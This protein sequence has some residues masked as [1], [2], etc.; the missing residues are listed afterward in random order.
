[1]SFFISQ[2]LKITSILIHQLFLETLTHYQ[3]HQCSPSSRRPRVAVGT[4]ACSGLVLMFQLPHL[5]LQFND[6]SEETKRNSK[7]KSLRVGFWFLCSLM[8]HVFNEINYLLF[9]KYDHIRYEN[10]SSYL[11][12]SDIWSLASQSLFSVETK[13]FCGQKSWKLKGANMLQWSSNKKLNSLTNIESVFLFTFNSSC[14]VLRDS[15]SPSSCGHKTAETLVIVTIV[16]CMYSP[17]IYMWF[18]SSIWM[19]HHLPH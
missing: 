2:R 15:Y 19:I 4:K 1:M 17:L 7:H 16:S 6:E 14:S 3:T 9:C 10:W 13:F 5:R 18:W 8:F 11:F 12:R